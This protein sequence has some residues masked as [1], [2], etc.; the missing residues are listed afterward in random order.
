MGK[1]NLFNSVKD[2]IIKNVSE[3]D[4]ELADTQRSGA[5]S[6]LSSI[7]KKDG[8]LSQNPNRKGFIFEQNQANSFNENAVKAGSNYRAVVDS[9]HGVAGEPDIRIIDQTTGETVKT[10]QAKTGSTN[11]INNA[12]TDAK[13]ST[14]TDAFVTD[15]DYGM[16]QL[17][18]AIDLLDK[19]E[20]DS[21]GN[22]IETVEN[23][24]RLERANAYADEAKSI[25]KIEYDDIS[26]DPT[27]KAELEMQDMD[28]EFEREFKIREANKQEIKSSAIK[29]AVISGIFTATNESIV[30]LGKIYRG[31][32]VDSSILIDALKK[33]L[34]SMGEGG[35]RGALIAVTKQI[36]KLESKSCLPV[37]IVS[38]GLDVFKSLYSYLQ[39]EI[40]AE[41]LIKDVGP[42]NLANGLIIVLSMAIPPL[43]F[44]LMGISFMS[45]IWKEFD[46]SSVIEEYRK[47]DGNFDKAM[48]KI[49]FA[50][51]NCTQIVEKS[52]DVLNKGKEQAKSFLSNKFSALK[53]GISVKNT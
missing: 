52:S 13:Y 11:Y 7:T 30:I 37:L 45:T 22:P 3:K 35:V 17:D 9:P 23:L 15:M 49:D 40:T 46:L 38:I 31:E 10:Y 27:L 41:E 32:E 34:A 8:T 25:D 18:K 47:K 29:G 6:L 24:S 21:N 51:T 36:L 20:L 53:K 4:M 42:R 39:G 50:K 33:V 5:D 28:P 26:S 16:N 48:S 2:A 44:G 1:N 19:V 12:R 14:G 43:G